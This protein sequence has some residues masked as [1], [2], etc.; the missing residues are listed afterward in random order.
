MKKE[1]NVALV[2]AVVLPVVL[3]FWPFAM[4]N[5]GMSL[6]LRIIP[7]V[8][9]Q[10]LFCRIGTY[11]VIKLLPLILSGSFAA[12]GTYLFFTSAHW[13]NATAWNLIA[14]YLSPCIC[15]MAVFAVGLIRKKRL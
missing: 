11:R 2:M 6:F 10:V 12:W 8:A 7:S 4:W 5:D 1:I 14:D 3:L 9:I 15:C 13:V